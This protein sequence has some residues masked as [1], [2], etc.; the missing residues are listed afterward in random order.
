MDLHIANKPEEGSASDGS[1]VGENTE[2]SHILWPWLDVQ[3]ALWV[4]KKKESHAR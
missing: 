3:W 1:E 4:K 2:V